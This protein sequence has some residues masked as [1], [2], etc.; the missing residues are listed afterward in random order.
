MTDECYPTCPSPCSCRLEEVPQMFKSIRSLRLF[1]LYR[2]ERVGLEISTRYTK[3]I[4]GFRAF[5][6][7]TVYSVTKCSFA[8]VPCKGPLLL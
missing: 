5:Y 6:R 2:A 7:L 3:L 8:V 4:I 1:M